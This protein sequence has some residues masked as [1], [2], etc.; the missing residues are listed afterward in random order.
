MDSSHLPN[1]SEGACCGTGSREWFPVTELQMQWGRIVQVIDEF[2]LL[3]WNGGRT[4]S[5]ALIP[6][7]WEPRDPLLML[8]G[9]RRLRPWKIMKTPCSPQECLL[10]MKNRAT[11]S[12]GWHVIFFKRAQCWLVVRGS[13]KSYNRALVNKTKRGLPCVYK[14]PPHPP[15]LL[16]GLLNSFP[17]FG[18]TFFHRLREAQGSRGRGWGCE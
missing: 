3:P 12:T 11:G 8:R 18:A 14:A 17:V 10:Q 6:E 13:L 5:L 1:Y 16:L 9:S 7:V 15:L 4:A 2:N